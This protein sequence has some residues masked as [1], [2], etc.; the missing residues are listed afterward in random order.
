MLVKA[1][2]NLLN[3]FGYSL[4]NNKSRRG[5]NQ[6]NA[7]YLSQ[8]CRPKT[9]IDVGVSFGTPEL[10]RAFP[11]A[12][13]ILI[14]PVHEY[15][16]YIDKILENHQGE[17]HYAAVGDQ[18]GEIS[19]N[20]NK[21]NLHLSSTFDRSPTTR[22]EDHVIETRKVSLTTID[23]IFS[24][25]D[26]LDGPILMKIDTEGGELNVLKGARSALEKIDFVIT[27]V[28]IST[29]FEGSYSF[30]ELC[31]YMREMGFYLY[32]FLSVAQKP[33]GLRPRFA[34][35]VFARKNGNLNEF[36]H[37]SSPYWVTSLFRFQNVQSID[38][39]R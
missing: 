37:I 7:E 36:I 29:R 28:S 16:S 11:S 33:D 2:N 12:Y 39:F 3:R 8:I 14:E 15:R 26:L 4:V 25:K 20:V 34:D 21:A 18:V 19:I 23:A 5:F 27:E 10:Y 1:V 17:V 38:K 6:Y 24:E 32:T 13:L 22:R 35:L 9:I 31:W 30:E